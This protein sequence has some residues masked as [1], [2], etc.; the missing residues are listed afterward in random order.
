MPSDD[1]QQKRQLEHHQQRE[2]I[3]V[4]S[5]SERFA[6]VCSD[7]RKSKRVLHYLF[8]C[9]TEGRSINGRE[10]AEQVLGIDVRPGI[11]VSG[12]RDQCKQ[13]RDA[14]RAYDLEHKD[15][16]GWHVTLPS[17]DA[18]NGYRLIFK[19]HGVFSS[20]EAFWHAHYNPEREVFVVCNEPVFFRESKSTRIFRYPDVNTWIPD[21][22]AALA[23]LKAGHSEAP[24]D[25]DIDAAYQYL[26][27]GEILAAD[28]IQSWFRNFAET[29]TP[30]LISRDLR[31]EQ[32]RHSSPVLL[33]NSRVNRFIYE[34]MTTEEG[35]ALSYQSPRNR[36]G[37]TLVRD[38]KAHHK[39]QKIIDAVEGICYEGDDAILVDEPHGDVYVLV[40]RFPNP[41]DGDWPITIISCDY[42][43]ALEQ[44]ALTLT[45]DHLLEKSFAATHWP[46]GRPVAD[47]FQAIYAV[48]LGRSNID[49]AGRSAR[50]VTAR[51]QISKA[52]A[53]AAAKDA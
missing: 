53:R 2:L 31:D 4:I 20:T 49:A 39:E 51:A 6:S 36:F 33:G 17:A 1:N 7:P 18:K 3:E 22:D 35:Q 42:T 40:T 34:A 12:G 43:R 50:L 41:Y 28:L 11:D 44:V 16:E 47:T 13:V 29:N 14:L 48:R 8:R 52:L 5:S 15:K 32:I 38:L 45:D 37:V 19:K 24:H 30:R 10:I 46:E 25:D 21:R 23:V 9:H 27:T 26:Y